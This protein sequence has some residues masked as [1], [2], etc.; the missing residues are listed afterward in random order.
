[1]LGSQESFPVKCLPAKA[2]E[3]RYSRDLKRYE[4]AVRLIRHDAWT[5]TVRSWT[6]LSDSSVLRIRHACGESARKGTIAGRRGPVPRRVTRYLVSRRNRIESAAFIGLCHLMGLIPAHPVAKAMRTYPSIA[7][8]EQVCAAF[9]RFRMLV[10]DGEVTLDQLA[11]LL[12]SVVEGAALTLTRCAGCGTI[13][14]LDLSGETSRRCLLCE[15]LGKLARPTPPSTNGV[16]SGFLSD[17]ESLQGR[18]FP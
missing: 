1:M 7:R 15:E 6:G 13:W 2:A 11:R 18:L 10:P 14:L 17:P 4:L 16:P 8:G 9:E 5:E 12:L 3:D